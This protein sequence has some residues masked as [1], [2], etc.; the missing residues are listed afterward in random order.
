MLSSQLLSHQTSLEASLSTISSRTSS[1]PHARIH[2]LNIC[3]KNTL[4]TQP[5][6]NQLALLFNACQTHKLDMMHSLP[7]L[8]LLLKQTLIRDRFKWTHMDLMLRGSQLVSLIALVV[9][10]Q[11]WTLSINK[12]STFRDSSVR[13][14]G[15]RVKRNMSPSTVVQSDHLSLSK[16]PSNLPLFLPSN[17]SIMQNARWYRLTRKTK[18][19]LLLKRARPSLSRKKS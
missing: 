6:T 14:E 18:R 7:H 16:G 15:C 8:S 19:A 4:Q 10:L 12:L 2:P 11:Q 5:D 17:F 13:Q 3:S 9:L 1:K